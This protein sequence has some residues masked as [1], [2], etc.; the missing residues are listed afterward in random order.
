MFRILFPA[1]DGPQGGLLT[2][3]WYAQPLLARRISSLA[4]FILPFLFFLLA[5]WAAG[6]NFTLFAGGSA[7]LG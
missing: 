2:R 5:W 1:S 4:L 6:A 7:D 3:T